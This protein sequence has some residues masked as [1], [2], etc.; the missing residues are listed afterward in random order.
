MIRIALCAVRYCR[1]LLTHVQDGMSCQI[2][3]I[4]IWRGGSQG[5]E[6]DENADPEQVCQCNPTDAR[7]LIVLRLTRNY[8]FHAH[9]Y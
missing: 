3:M 6:L 5:V 8:R 2:C 7:A 1:H 4:F 9:T